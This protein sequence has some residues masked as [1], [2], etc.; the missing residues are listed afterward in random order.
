MMATGTSRF[1]QPK[2]NRGSEPVSSRQIRLM[3]RASRL[4]TRLIPILQCHRWK[5]NRDSRSN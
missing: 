5:S 2:L 4:K 3:R 1:S